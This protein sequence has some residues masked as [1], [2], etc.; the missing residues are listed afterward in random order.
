MKIL[1][2]SDIHGNFDSLE[3][4][5][6]DL[7][8][9]KFDQIIFLGDSITYGPEPNKVLDFLLKL[10]DRVDLVTIIGNH[11]EYYLD[12]YM[13]KKNFPP[14]VIECIELTKK[15]LDIHLLKSFNWVDDHILNG[16][17][18]SHANPFGSGDWTYLNTEE[19]IM[20]AKDKIIEK[21]CH[22]G[23]FGHSHRKEFVKYERNSFVQDMKIEKKIT[24][25]TN[26]VSYLN[27]G[28]AGQPR[29]TGATYVVLNVFQS[30]IIAE[31]RNI[32]YNVKNTIDKLNGQHLLEDTKNRLI[33][34]LKNE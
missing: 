4:L 7:D 11:E 2:F 1:V 18:F 10:K 16:I 25:E 5:F 32:N 3:T 21:N 30:H 24:L 6:L 29:G 28:S 9:N 23:V 27:V 33:K 14:F 31:Y 8:T 12:G 20:Y 26:E 22:L 19:T 17:Y 13:G 15:E 34:Y